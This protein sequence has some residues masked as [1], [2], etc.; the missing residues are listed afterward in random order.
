MLTV[1][2]KGVASNL[3]TLSLSPTLSSFYG[4]GASS[5]T[6]AV[7]SFNYDYIK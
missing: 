4:G 3:T 5:Y 2:I 6:V 1:K 7:G